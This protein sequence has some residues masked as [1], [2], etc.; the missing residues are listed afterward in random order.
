MKNCHGGLIFDRASLGAEELNSRTDEPDYVLVCLIDGQAI[1]WFGDWFLLSACRCQPGS[2]RDFRLFEC[3]GWS[4][5]ERRTGVEVGD[6]GDVP[7]VCIA[8]DGT[9]VV[10]LHGTSTTSLSTCRCSTSLLLFFLQP[11]GDPQFDYGLPGD[12]KAARLSV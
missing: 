12:A 5:S 4:V 9:D 3:F 10:V 8:I 6:V 2:F 1:S 7:S 11:L